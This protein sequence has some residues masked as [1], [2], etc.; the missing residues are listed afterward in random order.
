MLIFFIYLK[1][2]V[3]FASIFGVHSPNFFTVRR[4]AIVFTSLWGR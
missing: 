2:Y 4:N 1:D 3:I